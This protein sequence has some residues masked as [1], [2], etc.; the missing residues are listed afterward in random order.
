MTP[1][2]KRAL[3]EAK[4][5]ALDVDGIAG[6]DF[7][8]VYRQRRRTRKRGI[9]FHVTLKWPLRRIVKAERLPDAIA[10]IECDVV[11]ARYAPHVAAPGAPGTIDPRDD[12]EL[13]RPGL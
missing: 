11:E 8:F 4:R 9:R 2:Q 10:G 5:L 3:S 7:G 13:L 12:S 6:V 1:A